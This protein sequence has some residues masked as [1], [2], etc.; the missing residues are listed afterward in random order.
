MQLNDILAD[1]QDQDRGRDFDLLD[2]V[3]GKPTGIT[4]RVAGPDSATQHRAR[5]KLAD[6][7]AEMADADGRVTAVDREKLRIACL[8]ACVLGWDIEEDGEPVPFSQ[9]NVIRVLSSAQWV[10]AQVDAFASDRAAFRGDR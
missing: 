2:P 4:F 9:K 1:V 10:Q 5:L 8:A 3:T 6:D 7:M